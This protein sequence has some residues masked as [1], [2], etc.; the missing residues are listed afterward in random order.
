MTWGFQGGGRPQGGWLMAILYPLGHPTPYASVSR[1]YELLVKGNQVL[2]AEE[3][4]VK[5]LKQTLMAV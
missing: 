1:P 4:L 2:V 3:E 5:S